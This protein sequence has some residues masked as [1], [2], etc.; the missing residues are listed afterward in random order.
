MVLKSTTGGLSLSFIVYV[1]TSSDP[2]VALVG[3]DNVTITVSFAS[4][5][6]SFTIPAI[7]IVPDVFPALIVKVPFASV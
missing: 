2:S 1:C 3:L 4:S 7:V 6:V 5:R